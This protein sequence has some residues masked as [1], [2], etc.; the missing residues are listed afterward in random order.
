MTD[1]QHRYHSPAYRAGF[2]ERV[3]HLWVENTWRLVLFARVI[4][5]AI[6][7]ANGEH[8]RTTIPVFARNVARQVWRTLLRSAIPVLVFGGVLGLAIGLVVGGFGDLVRTFIDTF[9]LP[10]IYRLVLPVLVMI[11]LVARIGSAIAGR[12]TTYPLV[13]RHNAQ[14]GSDDGTPATHA[15]YMSARELLAEVVPLIL[16]TAITAMAA[17]WLLAFW[18]M[19]GYMSDGLPSQLLHVIAPARWS[20]FGDFIQAKSL[21]PILRTGTWWSLGFG[22]AIAYIAAALGTAAG[23][24]IQNGTAEPTDYYDAVWESGAM[25]MLLCAGLIALA[26]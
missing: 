19:A 5:Q 21:G 3:G 13:Y 24:R 23:E 17:Y 20:A 26:R 25:T 22:F 6:A 9:A 15:T 1:T 7:R 2:V 8:R 18:L 14:S 10:V 11:I 12:L 16:A 4:A